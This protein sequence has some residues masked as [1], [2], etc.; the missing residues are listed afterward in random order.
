M[1]E[2]AIICDEGGVVVDAGLGDEAV[3]EVGFETA[4][5]EVGAKQ[6][7]RLPE[8]WLQRQNGQPKNEIILLPV[9]DGLLSSSV[10]TTGGRDVSLRFNASVST[11]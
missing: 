6:S 7:R 4:A 5:E 11:K 10:M 9:S 3:G 8:S 1:P 2:V